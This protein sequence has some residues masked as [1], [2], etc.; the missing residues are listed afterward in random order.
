MGCVRTVRGE[1]LGQHQYYTIARTQNTNLEWYLC[2]TMKQKR[3]CQLIDERLITARFSSH[4]FNVII[5]QVYARARDEE[6]DKF[7]AELQE[8]IDE[9]D[10]RGIIIY[11]G[12][13]NAKVGIARQ[14]WE[15]S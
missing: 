4:P 10:K 9:L 1:W 7:Y 2:C 12:D 13:W 6:I 5:I 8:T 11:M 14:N 15:E 3:S